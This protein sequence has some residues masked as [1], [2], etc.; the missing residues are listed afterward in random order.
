MKKTN[1]DRCLPLT[2]PRH[3]KLPWPGLKDKNPLTRLVTRVE[4]QRRK[5]RVNELWA[6]K[7]IA[8]I[9]EHVSGETAMRLVIREAR[10]QGKAIPRLS[11]A[12]LRLLE[13]M[14]YADGIIKFEGK[15]YYIQRK[16]PWMELGNV[17]LLPEDEV[18]GISD[19][20][21]HLRRI[22][23]RRFATTKQTKSHP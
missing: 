9:L 23:A 5:A 19:I 2:R 3:E 17:I 7:L 21:N 18:P 13:T 10:N 14:E 8:R 1:L 11:K 20:D 6:Q 4:K 16:P 22:S 12:L 15:K